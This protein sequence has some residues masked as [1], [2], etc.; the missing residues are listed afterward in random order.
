MQSLEV[1]CRHLSVRASRLFNFILRHTLGAWVARRFHARYDADVL[2]GLPPPY[3]VVG[4]HTCFWDPFL[5]S[6]PI[7][8]PVHFVASDEY[9]PHTLHALCLLAGWRH[10]KNQKH[11]RYADGTYP[12]GA[13]APRVAV[14]G[15]YPE[16]NR[17]WDGVTGPFVCRHRKNWS[18]NLPFPWCLSKAPA[19]H[20]HSP[21]GAGTGAMAG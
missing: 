15:L 7:R 11:P 1:T 14:L 2:E 8:Y 20:S 19:A 16:G 6:V 9:F 13:Q 12:A 4:N 17:N 3:L 10:S 5:L 18:E 21:D